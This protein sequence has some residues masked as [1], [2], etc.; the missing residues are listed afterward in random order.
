MKNNSMM[1]DK[2][3]KGGKAQVNMLKRGMLGVKNTQRGAFVPGAHA[4]KKKL[5]Y[6]IRSKNPTMGKARKLLTPSN[7]PLSYGRLASMKTRK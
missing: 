3:A 5:E 6:A 1:H 4:L 2:N 7:P